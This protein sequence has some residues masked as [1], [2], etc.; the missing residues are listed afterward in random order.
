MKPISAIKIN[1]DH[2]PSTQVT[3]EGKEVT[4]YLCDYQPEITPC[5]KPCS[6]NDWYKCTFNEDK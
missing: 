5:S 2:C 4:R 3:I 6:M 1:C